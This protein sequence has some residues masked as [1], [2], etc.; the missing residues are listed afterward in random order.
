[1]DGEGCG[2]EGEGAGTVQRSPASN[3]METSNPAVSAI[4]CRHTSISDELSTSTRRR[5]ASAPVSWE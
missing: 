4:S 3:R 2:G 1:M 5:N